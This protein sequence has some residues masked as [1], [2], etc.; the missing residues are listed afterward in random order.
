[1]EEKINENIL[2]ITG[3][4]NIPEPLKTGHEYSIVL[5]ADCIGVNKRDNHD[6]TFN[7]TFLLRQTGEA[8]ITTDRGKIIQS[9]GRKSK[10]KALRGA[11]WHFYEQNEEQGEFEPFYE[12]MMD[13]IIKYLPEILE[14][15]RVEEGK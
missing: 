7:Y 13:L 12:K 9:K 2:R 14:Y 15:I 11:L 4:S 1:M 5:K 10:S 3:S 6:G 8:I